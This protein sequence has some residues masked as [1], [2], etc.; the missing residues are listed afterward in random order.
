MTS[1]NAMEYDH[2]FKVIIV[3]EAGV[4]KSSLLSRFVDDNCPPQYISTIGVDFKVASLTIDGKRVKI[5]L[6]DTAGQE[7]F[8]SIVSSYY[9]GANGVMMVY[10]TNEARSLSGLGRFFKEISERSCFNPAIMIVGNK[11]DLVPSA[12]NEQLVQDCHCMYGEDIPHIYTSA[13]EG[14]N[15]REAFVAMVRA[16]ILERETSRPS[17]DTPASS[18]KTLS[19]RTSKLSTSSSSSLLC[20]RIQ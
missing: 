2:I 3:G 5:V 1:V 20:C 8:A 14:S 4:G 11:S 15:V 17:S 10:D 16:M 12:C 7:R 19:S 18:A 9:R 6:W 13:K